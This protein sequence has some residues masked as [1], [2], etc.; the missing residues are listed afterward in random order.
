MTG[1]IGWA[2]AAVALGLAAAGWYVLG[3]GTP[4]EAK[5]NPLGDR[6]LG[7]YYRMTA[8]YTYK[9]EPLVLDFGISCTSIWS[10]PKQH[11]Y[12]MDVTAGP[13]LYGVRTKDGKAVVISTA[14]YCDTLRPKEPNWGAPE[15]FL[16]ITFVYD[17]PDTLYSAT[18]YASDEA[19][20]N[21]SSVLTEPKVRFERLTAEQLMK[22]RQTPTPNVVR[23]VTNDG[24]APLNRNLPRRKHPIQN[25]CVGVLKF[26][27]TPAG[28]EQVRKLWPDSRPD[29]WTL[30][31]GAELERIIYQHDPETLFGGSA[32]MTPD[33]TRMSGLPRTRGQGA[34]PYGRVHWDFT[35]SVYPIVRRQVLNLGPVANAWTNGEIHYDIDTRD[36]VR[37]FMS[38]THPVTN[39]PPSEQALLMDPNAKSVLK[40]R[41][42][43]ARFTINGM[44]IVAA[45]GAAI[46]GIGFGWMHREIVYR[47][48]T[49]FRET[50]V[51][52]GGFIGEQGDE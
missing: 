50:H 27:L 6:D 4:Q 19:Y 52:G 38:C 44:P 43:S 30:E 37:G 35:P 10:D 32:F 11:K 25:D 51:N 21:A 9:G 47:D 48:Q 33:S 23:S 34:V 18:L 7:V 14:N 31:S 1:K 16:P 22:L 2:G 26:E 46:E 42:R 39:G 8:E 45:S 24:R 3:G 40:D 28:R 12:S 20:H 17:D 29:Y 36:A 41:M 49:I 5:K 15:D 13:K